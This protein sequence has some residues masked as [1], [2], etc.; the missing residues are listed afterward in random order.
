M[1]PGDIT[2]NIRLHTDEDGKPTKAD[3]IVERNGLGKVGRVTEYTQ[4]S[5]LNAEIDRLTSEIHDLRLPSR[6]SNISASLV[7]MS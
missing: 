2:I 3:I 5:D 6:N 7:S 4:A 1:K